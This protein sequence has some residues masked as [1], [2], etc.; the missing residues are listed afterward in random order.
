[1]EFVFAFFFGVMS[2]KYQLIIPIFVIYQMIDINDKNL[3]VDLTEF[4]IGLLCGFF[5][6]IIVS[7]RMFKKVYKKFH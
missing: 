7:K 5:I 3:L 1:M 6:H 4:L 2:V